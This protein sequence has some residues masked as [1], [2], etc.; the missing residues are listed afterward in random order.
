[1]NE[2]ILSV[3]DL[4]RQNLSLRA[5]LI[6][7]QIRNQTLQKDLESQLTKQTASNS[8]AETNELEVNQLSP[9]S[10]ASSAAIQQ[11]GNNGNNADRVPDVPVLES[12]VRVAATASPAVAEHSYSY[13]WPDFIEDGDRVS[14]TKVNGGVSQY[15]GRVRFAAKLFEKVESY[16]NVREKKDSVVHKDEPPG[17]TEA[18]S[19]ASSP[20]L[21]H[22]RVSPTT[23]SALTHS[24]PAPPPPPPPPSLNIPAPPPPPPPLPLNV[25][26]PPP[27]PPLPPSLRNLKPGVHPVTI[28]DRRGVERPIRVGKIQWPPPQEEVKKQE[29][30]VGRLVIEEKTDDP[31]VPKRSADEV[32]QRISE[33]ILAAQQMA[34]Q[35]HQHQLTRTSPIAKE[36]PKKVLQ[37]STH[38]SI[39]S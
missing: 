18:N 13:I 26:A 35:H 14:K 25:P 32:R 38:K 12:D 6:A 2:L 3:Q 10:S 31:N 33:R 29:I 17:K 22:T 5:Q 1:M 21:D 39:M 24:I 8:N 11:K 36:Y 4:K 15:G 30:E 27:P 9:S 20:S 28:R 16:E 37:C 19:G 7:Q 34:V 23:D